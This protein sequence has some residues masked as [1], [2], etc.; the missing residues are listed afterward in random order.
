MNTQLAVLLRLAEIQCFPEE[1]ISDL[2]TIDFMEKLDH[3]NESKL[4]IL[5]VSDTAPKILF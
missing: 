3:Y 5:I 4:V 1:Q 2:F